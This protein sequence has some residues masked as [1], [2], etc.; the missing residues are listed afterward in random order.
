MVA[1]GVLYG[2]SFEV[3]ANVGLR[4]SVDSQSI[5]RV[6]VNTPGRVVDGTPAYEAASQGTAAGEKHL[7]FQRATKRSLSVLV[8]GLVAGAARN[9]RAM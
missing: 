4:L 5:G 9:F 7:D 1:A 2:L 3:Q 8:Q 6:L